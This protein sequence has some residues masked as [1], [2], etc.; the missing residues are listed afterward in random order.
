[1]SRLNS[2]KKKVSKKRQSLKRQSLK[3][4]TKGY[5]LIKKRN[6]RKSK[7]G[8]LK[9]GSA[10][11][12]VSFEQIKKKL[13]ITEYTYHSEDPGHGGSGVCAIFFKVDKNTGEIKIRLFKEDR[14]PLFI[15]QAMINPDADLKVEGI[16]ISQKMEQQVLEECQQLWINY[17][18]YRYVRADLREAGSSDNEPVDNLEK[19][20]EEELQ[21][22]FKSEEHKNYYKQNGPDFWNSYTY[23]RKDRKTGIVTQIVS[24][25]PIYLVNLDDLEIDSEAVRRHN[26]IENFFSMGKIRN[27]HF[28]DNKLPEELSDDILIEIFA[29]NG[30]DEL[31]DRDKKVIKSDYHE[32]EPL[33]DYSIEETVKIV[34]EYIMSV[35]D[36]K[37]TG[38]DLYKKFELS[39]LG[40]FILDMYQ[41]VQARIADKIEQM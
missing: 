32:V 5:S 17:N 18:N 20:L 13:G 29:E 1:M 37:K 38:N 34:Q 22:N 19:L 33:G 10:G 23:E 30:S 21:M 27:T 41:E 35:Y 39:R 40:P 11:D 3:R 4:H 8:N 2:L 9:G 15:K 24:T 36:A 12:Q 25:S 14:V 6:N 26:L 28:P 7:K 16:N 31:A